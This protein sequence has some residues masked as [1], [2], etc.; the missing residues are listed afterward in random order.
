MLFYHVLHVT[1]NCV[2]M[3]YADILLCGGWRDAIILTYTLS[4]FIIIL[5]QSNLGVLKFTTRLIY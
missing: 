1:E 3:M 2:L 4:T 5:T